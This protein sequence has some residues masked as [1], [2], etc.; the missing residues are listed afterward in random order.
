M[1]LTLAEIKSLETSIS[2]IF[3][4]DINIKLAYKLSTLI[5]TLSEELRKL[6]EG[7]V[8]LVKKYGK[9]DEKTGQI[10]V[11]TEETQ[12][13]YKE[14]NELMQM[15]I[16]VDFEPIPLNAFG[17]IEISASDVLS[18]D[19]KILTGEDSEKEKTE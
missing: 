9:T 14:F 1:K 13:F 16:E 5:K 17:D 3:N 12:S 8:K 7:R 15:E 6:E 2:K 10:S 19:G 11:N 18:L 4:K